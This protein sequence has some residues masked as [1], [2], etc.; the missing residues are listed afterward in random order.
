MKKGFTLFALIFHLLL[1][2]ANAQEIKLK[3]EHLHKDFYVYTTYMIYKGTATPANGMYLVTEQGVVMFDTPWDPSQ[4]QPLLDSIAK[5]HHKKVV[6]AF[7]THSH[8]DRTAGLEFLNDL[9][10]KTFTTWQT[11]S[12]SKLHQFKRAKNHFKSDTIFQL[13]QYSFQTFYPGPGHTQDNIVI[14]FPNDKILYGGCFVKSTEAKDLG[15]LADANTNLW[16]IS[17]KNVLKNF[18]NTDFVVPGHQSWKNKFSI[19]HTMKLLAD[20]KK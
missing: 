11:D 2:H 15:N 12:I 16:P 5:K 19:E 4:N 10:V 6:L 14:W 17:L 3:I 13:G 20:F 1:F 9:G 18:P 7:A 8:E